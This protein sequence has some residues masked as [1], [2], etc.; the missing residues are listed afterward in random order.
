[1]PPHRF[2]AIPTVVM[3]TLIWI[4]GLVFI[5]FFQFCADQIVIIKDACL[6]TESAPNFTS[7]GS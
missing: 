6:S 2:S 7:M 4:G 5:G 3:Y 1:M